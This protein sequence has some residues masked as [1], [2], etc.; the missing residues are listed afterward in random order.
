[1]HCSPW[2]LLL[3]AGPETFEDACKKFEH[4]LD[5]LHD[6]LPPYSRAMQPVKVGTHV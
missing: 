3:A 1:M 2:A 5:E 4:R 6:M